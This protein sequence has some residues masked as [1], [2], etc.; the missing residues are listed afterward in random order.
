MQQTAPAAAP[1]RHVGK[2]PCT[3]RPSSHRR[4]PAAACVASG[5]CWRRSAMTPKH[6]VLLINDAATGAAAQ[7]HGPA[8]GVSQQ[9][10]A[11][12]SQRCAG[13]FQRAWRACR[14][15]AAGTRSRLPRL[16]WRT[17][18]S[19]RSP[20]NECVRLRTTCAHKHWHACTRARAHARVILNRLKH[21]P[22]V[23]DVPWKPNRT[24]DQ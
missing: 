13:A 11:L 24:S 9:R 18:V 19:L 14:P 1:A 16:H 17:R 22:D 4:R 7:L 10:I 23:P 12:C 15:V 5:P 8:C 20:C 21:I 6:R 3:S 2:R